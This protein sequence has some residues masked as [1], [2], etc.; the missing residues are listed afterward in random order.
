MTGNLLRTALSLARYSWP[1]FPC[2]PGGKE[3]CTTSGFQDATADSDQIVKWWKRWPDANIGIATGGAGPGVVDFDRDKEVLPGQK[4]L[5]PVADGYELLRVAGFL[6]G[7]GPIVRT[8]SGGYHL[9]FLGGNAGNAA[10]I[11]GYPIDYRGLGGYVITAPSV[12]EGRSY[13]VIASRPGVRVFDLDAA[14]ALLA[15]P[16]PPAKPEPEDANDDHHEY[17]GDGSAKTL[18]AWVAKAEK[19]ERTDRTFWA[20]CKCAENGYDNEPV[21]RAAVDDLGLDERDIRRQA[22]NAEKVAKTE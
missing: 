1:V 9:Y 4:R 10:K 16:P 7:A 22:A 11:G 6:N 14:K 20:L 5:A 2:H 17:D 18:A 15:P 8:G 3:P 13:E 12:V 21:I 19:G